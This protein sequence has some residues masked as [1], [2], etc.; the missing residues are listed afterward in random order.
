[1]ASI[2]RTRS[3]LVLLTTLGQEREV[4]DLLRVGTL[5]IRS[6]A[7]LSVMLRSLYG[8]EASETTVAEPEEWGL[9]KV[10]CIFRCI[11]SG[12]FEILPRWMEG[13]VLRSSRWFAWPGSLEHGAHCCF[14]YGKRLCARGSVSERAPRDILC[15]RSNVRVLFVRYHGR[16]KSHA[17]FHVRG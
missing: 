3:I 10:C 2:G 4:L 16:G 8:E 1:M 9:N 15:V 7:L 6:A 14:W 17:V 13:G 12:V 5:G 11:V